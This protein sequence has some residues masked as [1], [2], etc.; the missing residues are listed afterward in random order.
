MFKRAAD[1]RGTP[2]VEVDQAVCNYI[3]Y[4]DSCVKEMFSRMTK[5]DG[6]GVALFPFKLLSHSFIIGGFGGTFE[7]DKEKKSNDNL[8]NAIISFRDKVAALADSSNH[9]AVRKAEHYI[10]ALNAQIDVCAQTDEMIERL[11]AP[12]PA[13]VMYGN[14]V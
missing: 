4:C 13:H 11:C 12:F 6:E 2:F 1:E 5:S 3:A 7:P 10:G 14:K 8:R 9:D